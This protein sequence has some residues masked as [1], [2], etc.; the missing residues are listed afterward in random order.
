MGTA[1]AYRERLYAPGAKCASRLIVAYHCTYVQVSAHVAGTESA[2]I[3]HRPMQ[4]SGDQQPRGDRWTG[5]ECSPSPKPLNALESIQQRSGA[6]SLTQGFRLSAF[7]TEAA[8]GASLHVSRKALSKRGSRA[9]KQ[10]ARALLAARAATPP[11]LRPATWGV[12]LPAGPLTITE[13]QLRDAE[14]AAGEEGADLAAYL[15]A[16]VE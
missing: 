7:R 14:A 16:C 1:S 6:A 4:L 9:A 10:A 5:T 15:V 12:L 2:R 13:D 8:D 11:D 3:C